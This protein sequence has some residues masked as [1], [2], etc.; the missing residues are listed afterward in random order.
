M[1]VVCAFQKNGIEGT[2]AQNRSTNIIFVG[3]CLFL[4][5]GFSKKL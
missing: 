1:D 2:I 3:C 4:Y 5:I